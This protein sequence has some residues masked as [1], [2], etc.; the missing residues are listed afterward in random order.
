MRQFVEQLLKWNFRICGVFI[1]D[2]QFLVDSSKFFSAVL[3]ALSVMVTLEIS[4]VNVMSKLD[5]LNEKDKESLNRYLEADINLLD[6]QA[7]TED[8]KYKKKFFKLTKALTKVIDDYS[9]VKFHPLDITDE[10]SINDMLLIVD[11]VLQYGE[12]QD[13]KEPREYEPQDDK[14]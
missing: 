12:D 6:E 1:I 8:A 2:A 14:D 13:V 11:N 9:L 7:Q 4:H 10:D 3:A 5:L